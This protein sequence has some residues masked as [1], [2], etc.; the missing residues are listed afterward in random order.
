MSKRHHGFTLIEL[1]V[2]IA[3]IAILAAILFPVFQKVRENARRASCLSNEKQLG[4]AFMQY[5]QDADEQLPYR[6]GTTGNQ[7]IWPVTIM[8]YI[9]SIAVFSC[10]DD[11][12]KSTVGFAQNPPLSYAA[13][14]NVITS[15]GNAIASFVAPASTV[16]LA[17]QINNTIDF[18]TITYANYDTISM[19]FGRPGWGVELVTGYLG[20]THSAEWTRPARH[21]DA[22]NFLALD[23]HAKWLQG[24]KV[25]PGLDNPSQVGAESGGTFGSAAGTGNSSYV[26]TFSR[27]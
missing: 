9:K 14:Q 12:T 25:S 27:L 7:V 21:S 2:V 3:I 11:S 18:T 4:L 6:S 15:P 22:S 8:P 24:V 20:T 5:T 19:T 13:N 1:L 23:G 10:P 16:L 17:E 26:M